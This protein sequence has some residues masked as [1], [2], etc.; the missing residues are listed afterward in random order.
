LFEKFEINGDSVGSANKLNGKI[1]LFSQ[2][3]W[4]DFVKR[5]FPKIC[6]ACLAEQNYC[7]KIWELSFITTCPHHNCLLINSCQNCEKGIRWDRPAL[8]SCYCGYD[9]RES[10]LTSVEEN[11]SEI[12]VYF[13]KEFGLS[14]C[15]EKNIFRETI[16]NLNGYCLLKL[17]CFI[18]SHIYARWSFS[19]I[20][21][22]TDSSNENIHAHL[23]RAIKLFDDWPNRFH[24]FVRDLNHISVGN[25]F[26]GWYWSVADRSRLSPEYEIYE[27]INQLQRTILFEEQF[28]FIHEFLLNLFPELPD[29]NVDFENDLYFVNYKFIETPSD[30]EKREEFLNLKL[31]ILKQFKLQS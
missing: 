2:P 23:C 11:I 5:V 19:G 22:L 27:L 30:F 3:K 14:C 12:F 29:N 9:F 10:K 8:N 21:L 20:P 28:S 31:R 24:Q 4:E 6:P 16:K 15:A 7:Q 25:Y 1:K 18:S 26:L 17:L 13:H